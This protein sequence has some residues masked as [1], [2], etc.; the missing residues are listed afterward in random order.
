MRARAAAAAATPRLPRRL[1]LLLLLAALARAA[2]PAPDEGQVLGEVFLP[3]ANASL[4]ESDPILVAHA[5]SALAALAGGVDDARLVLTRLE[6]RAGGGVLLRQRL[7]ELRTVGLRTAARTPSATP[8]PAGGATPPRPSPA[9]AGDGA[10]LAFSLSDSSITGA[11]QQAAWAAQVAAALRASFGD[12]QRVQRHFAALAM[13]LDALRGHDAGAPVGP[14]PTLV[15]SD[16]W[17]WAPPPAAA[18]PSELLPVLTALAVAL[19]VVAVAFVGLLAVGT[20]HMRAALA[21]GDRSSSSSSKSPF[22]AARR[23]TGGAGAAQSSPRAA[24]VVD[25]V[26][27]TTAPLAAALAAVAAASAGGSSGAATAAAAA[28]AAVAA[29]PAVPAAPSAAGA[30]PAPAT[31]AAPPT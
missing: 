2:R 6:D 25:L 14:P 30:A 27:F 11:A 3:A 20:R 24:A 8:P 29:P 17:A 10:T 31:G 1:P 4:F 12:A 18:A 22:E 23:G 26:P 28:A 19:S 13:E 5:R 9:A 16:H 15:W 21:H 7:L